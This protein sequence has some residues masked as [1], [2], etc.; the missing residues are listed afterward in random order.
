MTVENVYVH[1]DTTSNSV[2][3]RGISTADFISAIPD[4]P[5]NIL[6]LDPTAAGGEFEPHTGLKIVRGESA[7]LNYLS[8]SE[9]NGLP[10]LKW[11]DFKEIHFLQQLTPLEIAELLYFSHVGRQLHSPFFYKLQNNFV[12]FEQQEGQM[13][14]YYRHLESFYRV[15]SDALSQSTA[16][17]QH[18]EKRFFQSKVTLRLLPDELVKNLKPIFQDGVIFAFSEGRF[19]GD[20]LIVPYYLAEDRVRTVK[21]K[22]FADEDQ[23]GQLIYQLE[24]E[25]WI[26][27]AAEWDA[28]P[29]LK[30]V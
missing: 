6:L 27:Q 14:T 21:R 5:Q 13:K 4:K 25:S 28:L 18:R 16:A 7:C 20:Q 9:R 26:V 29:N 10:L 22:Q 2:Q 15:I 11:I 23:L 24:T 12:Y 3:T 1:L 19:T 17:V 30:Q 8:V